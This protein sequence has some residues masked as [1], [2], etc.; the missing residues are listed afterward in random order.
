MGFQSWRTR[1]RGLSVFLIL[2]V[3]LQLFSSGLV[4][5]QETEPP[6]MVARKLFEPPSGA[7]ATAPHVRGP[8]P[9][10]LIVTGII[11][12]GEQKKAL[13]MDKKAPHGSTG[14][15]SPGPWYRGGELVGGYL[16][17]KIDGVGVLLVSGDQKVSVPLF[18]TVK[19]RPQPVTVSR[20]L[21]GQGALAG[22]KG[23]FSAPQAKGRPIPSAPS[24]PDKPAPLRESEHPAQAPPTTGQAQA[25]QETRSS[26]EPPPPENANPFL[27]A[28][29]RAGQRPE[30]ET[31]GPGTPA[32]SSQ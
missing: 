15:S 23:A 31:A 13:I 20:P 1:Y 29:R 2:W 9:G 19:E 5:G 12:A 14:Q 26:E 25:F 4:S 6:P 16:L 21:S 24:S 10:T 28:L 11:L 27:E 30:P 7:G 17:E 8:D 32:T 3:G 18:G 22:Q